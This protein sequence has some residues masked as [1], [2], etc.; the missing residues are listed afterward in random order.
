MDLK[1]VKELRDLTGASIMDCRNA[2]EEAKGNFEKAQEI[3]KQK[4]QIIADK[5]ESR[6]TKAGLIEA[7]V[8]MNGKVGVLVDLRCETDFVAKNPLFKELA[9]DIA[10]QV[11]AMSPIYVGPDNIPE[12]II[13]KEKETYQLELKD[14]NKPEKIINQIIEG[15]LQKWYQEICL[16]KQPF[17]KNQDQIIEDVLKEYI[18]KIGENIKINRFVRFEI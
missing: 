17:I 1:Q 15:K 5:K 2:L 11:A 16:I 4:G 6:E 9:H 18:A 14:S 10:L 3:L 8:H 13:N 12:E 7:Y